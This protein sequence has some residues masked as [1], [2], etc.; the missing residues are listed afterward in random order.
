MQ[1]KL[2]QSPMEV[3][4]ALL[5]NDTNTLT[6]KLTVMKNI[7]CFLTIF[8]SVSAM[9]QVETGIAIKA[10][11]EF[12][13]AQRVMQLTPAISND[14]PLL[15]HSQVSQF[16]RP[17]NNLWTGVLIGAGVGLFSGVIGGFISGDDPENQ[18]FA[19]TAGEK[20][21]VGGA[22]FGLGGAVVGGVIG[23][24]IKKKEKTDDIKIN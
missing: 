11:S 13:P 12:T 20:A 1:L 15:I 16:Y 7:F 4:K 21:A 3:L 14:R 19:M 23:L 2:Q 24:F 17:N 10:N 6:I 22:I 18:W 8:F 5:Y 9:A